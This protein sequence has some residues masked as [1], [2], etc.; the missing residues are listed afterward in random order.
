MQGALER[1][2]E[3]VQKNRNSKDASGNNREIPKD[4]LMASLES[5]CPD[6]LQKHLQLH[7]SRLPCY[8][9]L[10]AEIVIYVET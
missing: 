5:M 8:A 1:W 9:E 10:R 6:D 4:M 3:L 7:A 2:E